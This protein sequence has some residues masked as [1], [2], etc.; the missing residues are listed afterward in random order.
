MDK[1][2]CD[3]MNRVL[4]REFTRDEIKKALDQMNPDKALGLDAMT[5]C[6]YKRYW[7]VSTYSS[8][9]GRYLR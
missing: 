7:S 4:D 1:R 9:S 8:G 2:I 5:V 3:E 6:F